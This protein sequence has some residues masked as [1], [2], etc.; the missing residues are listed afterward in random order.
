MPF[1]QI[2]DLPEPLPRLALAL[3]Q[4]PQSF[5]ADPADRLIVA[6]AQSHGL[7]LATYNRAIQASAM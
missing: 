3:D 1:L 2:R 5:H 7:P 6:T 4:L